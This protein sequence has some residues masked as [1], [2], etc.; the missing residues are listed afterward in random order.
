MEEESYMDQILIKSNH[1][2]QALNII[3]LFLL[4]TILIGQKV[5]LIHSFFHVF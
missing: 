2:S 3:I 5:V 4:I 1:Q